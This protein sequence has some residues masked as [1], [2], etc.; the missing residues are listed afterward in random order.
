[1][2]MT[3]IGRFEYISKYKYNPKSP[4]SSELTQYGHGL[5]L[6]PHT[7]YLPEKARCCADGDRK[8]LI[9]HIF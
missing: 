8:Q 7:S 2:N 3:L 6:T 9:R 4:F 5:N 1:M